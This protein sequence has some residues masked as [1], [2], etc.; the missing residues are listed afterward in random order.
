MSGTEAAPRSKRAAA[1]QKNKQLRRARRAKGNG[2]DEGIRTPGLRDLLFKD[3][4]PSELPSNFRQDLRQLYR[5]YL[6]EERLA[7]LEAMGR[8][9][10]AFKRVGCTLNGLL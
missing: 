2:R 5:F 6:V 4:R 8:I 3:L 9:R 10:R 1:R 7:Q